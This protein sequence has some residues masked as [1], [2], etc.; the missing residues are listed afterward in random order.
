MTGILDALFYGNLTPIEHIY[1]QSP[2]YQEKRDLYTKSRSTLMDALSRTDDSLT[3][4]LEGLESQRISLGFLEHSEAFR[5]G[6]SL[7]ITIM[8]EVSQHMEKLD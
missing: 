4:A 8:Q 5:L 1:P 6:F 2:E 3:Y 7:G